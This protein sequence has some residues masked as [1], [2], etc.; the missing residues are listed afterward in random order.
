MPTRVVSPRSH[1]ETLRKQVMAPMKVTPCDEYHRDSW[2]PLAPKQQTEDLSKESLEE[3]KWFNTKTKVW[4]AVAT[5][6]RVGGWSVENY[7]HLKSLENSRAASQPAFTGGLR[8]QAV[9]LPPSRIEVLEGRPVPAAVGRVQPWTQSA[10]FTSCLTGGVG[11]GAKGRNSGLYETDFRRFGP[12]EYKTPL[13][14]LSTSDVT[15][16]AGAMISQKILL[17]T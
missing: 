6:S 8:F 3:T 14:G 4:G 16:Q 10:A 15:Q 7:W 12:K 5:D 1:M 13:H 17:R 2:L 9:C 11:G